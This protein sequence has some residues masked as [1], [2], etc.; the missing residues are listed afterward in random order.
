MIKTTLD[1]EDD[2]AHIRL[3]GSWRIPNLRDI[4]ELHEKCSWRWTRRNGMKGYLITSEVEGY[5]DRSIFLP[6]VGFISQTNIVNYGHSGYYWTSELYNQNAKHAI[7]TVFDRTI[8]IKY[9]PNQ[10]YAGL[11]IRPVCD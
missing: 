1:P 8:L 6:A 3:G 5:T 11:T 2:V 4:A 7:A 9:L 10:R